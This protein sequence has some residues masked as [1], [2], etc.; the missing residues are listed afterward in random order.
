MRAKG[1][2]VVLAVL[3]ATFG[4]S[5]AAGARPS[6]ADA[7]DN[8]NNAAV[9]DYWS[10]DRIASAIPR[11]L[12]IAKNGLGYLRG[13]NGEL[14]PY[15]H[16]ISAPFTRVTDTP[17]EGTR[18]TPQGKDAGKLAAEIDNMS[19]ASGTTIGASSSFTV[20]V[21]N[22]NVRGVSVFVG[23]V[24]SSKTKFSMTFQGGETWQSNLEGFSNGDWEWYVEVREPR[25][26]RTYSN[27]VGFAVDTGS[28]G[29][30]GGGGGDC[31]STELVTNS[32]W[33]CGGAVQTAAGRILFTMGSSNY[34]CSGTVAT[35]GTSGRS[36]IITAA[37]CI[38]DE[39]ADA[40]ASNAI[41]IPSQDDG[42]SDRT[43]SNCSNDPIGCW[44]VDHGI[45]DKEWADRTWS[46]NIPWDYGYYVVSDTGAHSGTASSSA[47]DVAAGSLTVDF[48]APALGASA[49]AL[50][51]SYSDDP[52]FMHCQEGL[53]TYGVSLFLGSCGLSGGASGGPWLQPV[54]GGNGV[55]ISVNS[56]G[57][58]NQPGMGAP[59]LYNNSAE[60]LFSVAKSSDLAT[61]D[62]GF[63][64]DANNP[65]ST[66]STTST[67]T[68]STTS[69]STT[70]TTSTSTTSTTTTTMA[71]P[72]DMT[73]SV[74]AYKSKG[75]K[76]GQ[77]SWSGSTTAVDIYRDGSVIAPGEDN[78]GS[79]LDNTGQ[80]GGGTTSWQVCEA[81]GTITCSPIVTHTW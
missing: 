41:F 46:D 67:S 1:F 35:D 24:G 16:N 15:G 7:G 39:V 55:I 4:V 64:V 32:R 30:G 18:Y 75:R 47:L 57:W 53:G 51:Y 5:G 22:A 42:G 3:A 13:A 56:W 80:K 81:G 73:L 25:G 58:G 63:V 28:G 40:F 10:A 29:G 65:P 43:D 48:T 26:V 79:Y 14:T 6:G 20:T 61:A 74:T 38:Y 54:D 70:S 8:R 23:R 34:V 36:I 60:L 68:T 49:T 44:A 50:G 45:V 9:F 31:S 27:T 19:P 69:T 66:T 78:D 11:D 76:V 71:P 37:H 17:I 72:A 21:A 59:R 52:Y 12:V 33:T 2:V 62:R 77:L